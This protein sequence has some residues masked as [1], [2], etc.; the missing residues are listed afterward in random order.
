MKH[1]KKLT[2]I[3]LLSV[4]LFSCK[5]EEKESQPNIVVILCDDLGY[6]DLSGFGHPVIETPNL[7]KM[8]EDGIKFTSFYS[9][10][11]VCSPSRAGLLTGR[12]PNRAGI[13]DF[14]PGPRKSEDCRD[15][16]HLQA[17]EQTIP[18]MLKTVG[19]STCLSGKWHC[20]SHFNSDKQPTPGYFGF[21]HWFATHNNA[22]P[23]HENPKNFVRNGHDVGQLEGFSCQLVVDEALNWLKNKE[24]RNPFYLQVCF[25]EPHE[26]VASPAQLVEK[27]MSQ[28]ENEDQA[29]YFANVENMDKAVGQLIEYLK[30]NHGDNT[31]IVFSSDNGPETLMRYYRAKRSYGSPG[32]LKGMK[33]WTSEAGFRVPGVFRW[34][35]KETFNG[36]TDAVVSSLDFM[37]TFAEISGAT[38]PDVILDGQSIIPLIETGS[39]NRVK[40]LTW[41]FYDAINERMVA[42]RTNDWKIMCRLKSDT[43]YVENFHNIYDGNEQMIK[44]AELTDFVLYNMNEDIS[45]STDVSEKYPDKFEEMKELL[46][47]E[48]AALLEGSFVWERKE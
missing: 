46:K 45:E 37:P 21:D 17:H 19:Y 28:S 7:D 10:A 44:E 25:H 27:Y 8:A 41:A 5:T 48:Y 26:P 43:S 33:L 47:S 31:L 22:A 9:A 39:M 20:S 18:G 11:P 16:V 35:G 23:S 30:A 32:E 14:I 13:Y 6:G 29:Q 38:L 4:A 15:I 40:P 36:T 34:L 2:T 24:D 3:L 12:S 1:L 42:M